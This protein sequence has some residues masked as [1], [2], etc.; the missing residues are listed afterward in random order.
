MTGNHLHEAAGHLAQVGHEPVKAPAS[1]GPYPGS[2]ACPCRAPRDGA[3]ED[4]DLSNSAGRWD[5]CPGAASPCLGGHPSNF[6]SLPRFPHI[7][8]GDV[9]TCLWGFQTVCERRW[10][11]HSVAANPGSASLSNTPSSWLSGA[12]E[13]SCVLGPDGS[14]QS[15]GLSGL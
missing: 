12:S 8:D 9:L 5:S 4:T 1:P 11:F 10:D 13:R 6:A 14:W 7:R 2:F 3:E 15:E